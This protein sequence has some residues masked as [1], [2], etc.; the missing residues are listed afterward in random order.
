MNKQPKKVELAVIWHAALETNRAYLLRTEITKSHLNNR[1]CQHCGVKT[2]TVTPSF[3]YVF[4]IS[5]SCHISIPSFIGNLWWVLLVGNHLNTK[6]PFVLVSALQIWNFKEVT[7]TYLNFET[8]TDVSVP[9]SDDNL[10]SGNIHHVITVE[11]SSVIGFVLLLYCCCCC[12]SIPKILKRLHRLTIHS[13]FSTGNRIYLAV[14]IRA[15]NPLGGTTLLGL[16]RYVRPP[17]D[18]FFSH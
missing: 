8:Q 18:M 15:K 11:S 12:A 14:Q 13:N 3:Y 4:N 6:Y 1:I 9:D 2:S 7:G 17:K 5:L 10:S 16:Y